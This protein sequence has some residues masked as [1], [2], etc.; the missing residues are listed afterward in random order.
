MMNIR[1]KCNKIDE[2]SQYIIVNYKVKNPYL[3]ICSY[4]KI[5]TPISIDN[6]RYIIYNL[7]SLPHMVFYISAFCYFNYNA[8]SDLDLETEIVNQ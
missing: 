2:T 1:R 3:F 5:D 6:N 4:K 8:S 7:S